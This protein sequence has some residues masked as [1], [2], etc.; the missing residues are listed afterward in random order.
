EIKLTVTTK[1]KGDLIIK[2]D[3]MTV[4]TSGSAVTNPTT[5]S[6]LVVETTWLRYAYNAG[7]FG[8][9]TKTIEL[10]KNGDKPTGDYGADG[11]TPT[12]AVTND[13]TVSQ[14]TALSSMCLETQ[15]AASTTGATITMLDFFTKFKMSSQIIFT[16]IM[17]DNVQ[18]DY[19]QVTGVDVKTIFFNYV[20]PTTVRANYRPIWLDLI[21]AGDSVNWSPR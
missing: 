8:T 10:V 6:G 3:Q 12:V 4:V 20:D 14:A 5:G 15:L 19:P 18:S 11:V 17:V 21:M 9:T 16:A 13:I 2:V 1:A 7:A